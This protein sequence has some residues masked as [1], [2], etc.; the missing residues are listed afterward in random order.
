[1]AIVSK[2]RAQYE[3]WLSGA[4]GKVKS[5]EYDE[6]LSLLKRITEQTDVRYKDLVENAVKAIDKI[7][8]IAEKNRGGASARIEQAG[9]AFQEN[10]HQ[11]VIE[12]LGEIPESMMTEEAR[13][14]LG[15]SRHHLKQFASLKGELSACIEQ[16]DWPT[17]GH[18]LE[19]L[20]ELAPGD[21]KFT[22]LSKQVAA[23]LL[24]SAIKRL[25]R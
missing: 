8:S 3:G 2:R 17:A 19:Q 9:Q 15:K 10:D 23:K 7:E 4:I 1:M 20:L 14:W 24:K 18:I 21:A 13:G 12:C 6:A 25:D 16:R 11:R 22:K 5:H